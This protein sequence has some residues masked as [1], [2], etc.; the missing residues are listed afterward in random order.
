MSKQGGVVNNT[1]FSRE[2]VE[3]RDAFG[4]SEY[5]LE[6]FFWMIGKIQG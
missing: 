3:F 5:D 2:V 1:M 6:T 4:I